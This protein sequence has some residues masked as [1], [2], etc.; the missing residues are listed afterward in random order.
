MIESKLTTN[1][2][3]RDRLANPISERWYNNIV[4]LVPPGTENVFVP[5]MQRNNINVL[6]SE[7]SRYDENETA[8]QMLLNEH[9]LLIS[10]GL[11]SSNIFDKDICIGVNRDWSRPTDFVIDLVSEGL[12]KLG[13]RV[14]DN[15]PFT[16]AYSIEK[17]CGYN[18]ISLVVNKSLYMNEKT[19]EFIVGAAKLRN[20]MET[21]YGI[22]NNYWEEI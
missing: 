8:L 1:K 4:L 5:E 19:K 13:Y 10:I 18:A 22:L 12:E 16:F 2:D 17:D 3:L 15:K 21:L 14:G 7:P 6:I 11:C 9:S 20:D